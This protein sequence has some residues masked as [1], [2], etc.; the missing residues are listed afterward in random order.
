[1][2][3]RSK[4]I[5]YKTTELTQQMEFQMILILTHNTHQDNVTRIPQQTHITENISATQYITT[6]LQNP[7]TVTSVHFKASPQE[8]SQFRSV[9]Y[10]EHEERDQR[11]KPVF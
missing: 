9:L 10:Q 8:T 4:N 2:K 11:A 7:V 5:N 3:S 6:Q 1:L